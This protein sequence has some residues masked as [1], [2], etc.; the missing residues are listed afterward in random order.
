MTIFASLLN[1]IFVGYYSIEEPMGVPASRSNFSVHLGRVNP[2]LAEARV[3][4]ALQSTYPVPFCG[5]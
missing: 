5:R 4:S 1:G 3:C 2:C